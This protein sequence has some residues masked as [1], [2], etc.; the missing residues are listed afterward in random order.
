[1]NREK[2]L[3]QLKVIQRDVEREADK[4][5][6]LRDELEVQSENMD[7]ALQCLS[8]AIYSLE[9]VSEWKQPEPQETT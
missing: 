8:D 9:F 4:L 6:E 2:V 5:R 1:L 7:D 3:E